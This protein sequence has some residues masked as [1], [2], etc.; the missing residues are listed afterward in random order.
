[1]I[2]RFDAGFDAP[3]QE[4]PQPQRTYDL[5]PRGTFRVEI[6]KAERKAVP[7][8]ATTANPGGDCIT[9]RLRA[10]VGYSLVFCD[11]PDDKPWL[12]RHV[13]AAV[14]IVPDMCV[15]EELPGRQAQVEIDHVQTRDGRTKAVVRK[16]LP[17]RTTTVRP[18]AGGTSTLADAIEDW[19]NSNP[20]K[21][22]PPAAKRSRNAVPRH[23]ADDDIPF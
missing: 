3:P 15:P 2:D 1:M 21:A 18:Q 13:A 10:A 11:L 16:W 20:T 14:G 5:V 19:R 9:L 17:A 22:T 23:V 4:P 8:R 7:W 6:V 12:R